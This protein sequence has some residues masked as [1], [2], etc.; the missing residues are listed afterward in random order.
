MNPASQ[1]FAADRPIVRRCVL[2]LEDKLD[3]VPL[4]GSAQLSQY[5]R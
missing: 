2:W 4:Q 3:L 1:G 5:R